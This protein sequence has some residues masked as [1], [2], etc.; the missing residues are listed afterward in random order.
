MKKFHTW[1]IVLSVGLLA[2]LVWQIGLNALLSE[3]TTLGWGLVPLVLIEGVAD[4][5]HALGWRHCLSEPH[6]SLPFFRI[7]RI[8]MAGVSINYVTPAALGGEVAKGVLL[9]SDHNSAGA[10]SAVIIG[11][12]AYVLAQLLFVSLGSIFTLW[13][14]QLPA[15]VWP[16]LL[17]GCSILAVG[18]LAFLLVQKYGKLGSV[19][20]WLVARKIG[21]KY[22]RSAERH[23]TE[24]D[25]AL[26]QFYRDHPWGLCHAMLWHVLGLA[27]GTVQT[28][29]FLI[30]LSSH[31]SI[32][33]AAGIWFL[34][35]W[36]DLLTFAIPMSIGIQE[37]TRVIAFNAVGYASVVGLAFGV[38]LR[39]EQVFWA[40]FGLLC[41][42][43]L[44]H[45]ER[46]A[47][48][49]SSA[50]AR[51]VPVSFPGLRGKE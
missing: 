49:A 31:P 7:L 19:I 12:L 41:Y 24:V 29:L 9:S 28:W 17:T 46:R 38:T 6:R 32:L 13:G 35:T 30:L 26:R 40:A 8:R 15:G 23:I 48:G 10:I 51:A 22:L 3:L 2:L 25:D 5:F 36:F 18:I 21:G 45:E 47:K 39:L 37:A 20:R 33:V 1:C 14:V 4:I 11:K 50:S 27:V 34:S 16:A 42:M 43:S 44:L